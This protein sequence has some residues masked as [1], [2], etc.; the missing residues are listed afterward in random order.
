MRPGSSVVVYVRRQRDPCMPAAL[1]DRETRRRKGGICERADGD[2]HDLGRRREEVVDGGTALG[3][4]VVRPRLSAIGRSD[5]F[6]RDAGDVDALAW[7]P[8]LKSERAASSALAREAM[9]DRDAH[10]LS[11]DCES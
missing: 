4:E 8:R 10:R 6:A 7:E 11:F 1:P 3:A 2:R 9:A 5:V